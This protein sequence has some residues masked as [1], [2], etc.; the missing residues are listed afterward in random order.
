MGLGGGTI[1]SWGD[2]QERYL[3][4][5]QEYCRYREPREEIFKVM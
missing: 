2:M 5:Y 3:K 1:T 4:K